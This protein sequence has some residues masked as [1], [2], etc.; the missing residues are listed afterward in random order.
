LVTFV[1]ESE[2]QRNFRRHSRL[3]FAEEHLDICQE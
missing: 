3:L 2:T 1:G